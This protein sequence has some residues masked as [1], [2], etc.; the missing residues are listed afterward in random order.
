MMM[1]RRLYPSQLQSSGMGH[2]WLNFDYARSLMVD[3]G[4]SE[5]RRLVEL[6]KL[7]LVAEELQ[8]LSDKAEKAKTKRKAPAGERDEEDERLR[9]V[10]T[11]AESRLL[12]RT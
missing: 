3:M 6:E 7:R 2:F 5:K 9:R 11:E 4:L 1:L 8:E 12:G 10:R